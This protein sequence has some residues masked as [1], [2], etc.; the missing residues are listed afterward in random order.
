MEDS[1]TRPVRWS[2]TVVAVLDRLRASGRLYATA[3][4]TGTILDYDR[5]TILNSIAA[6]PDPGPAGHEELA[7]SGLLDPGAA[8][9]PGRGVRATGRE[10]PRNGDGP[11]AITPQGRPDAQIA[12]TATPGTSLPSVR[13]GS[14][15]RQQVP[16]AHASVFGAVGRRKSWWYMYRCRTCSAYL[17]GRARSLDAVAEERRAGSVHI[18]AAR[19][20]T[21]PES[22]ATA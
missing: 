10:Q 6:E 16:I 5:R 2:E 17:F 11:G 14:R 3:G 20:Y 12:A 21:Q 9:Y 13:R 1:V 15:N 19:T 22:G 18:M 7:H 4:E 8:R